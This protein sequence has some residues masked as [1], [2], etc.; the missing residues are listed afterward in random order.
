MTEQQNKVRNA[1]T[2][3]LRFEQRLKRIREPARFVSGR[4]NIPGRG[5]SKC[6]GPEVGSAKQPVC[7]E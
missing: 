3:K 2:E 4:K 5:N 1:L 6:K 7:Q